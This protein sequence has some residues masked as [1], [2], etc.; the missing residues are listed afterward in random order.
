MKK[1]ALGILITMVSLPALS[2]VNYSAELLSG[3]TKHETKLND[4]N[5]WGKKYNSSNIVSGFGLRGVY[6]I[7]DIFSAELAYF[8]YG[9]ND[10]DFKFKSVKVTQKISTTSF[11]LGIKSGVRFYEDYLVYLRLGT[12]FWLV[13][14]DVD[15]TTPFGTKNQTDRDRNFYQGGGLQYKINPQ[16]SVGAE[17]TYTEMYISLKGFKKEEHEIRNLSLSL[18]YHF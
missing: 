8:D 10:E 11:N 12:S 17:F 14:A 1:L 5:S 7:G 3:I 4:K 15:L 13:K 9:D 2:E 16:F 18:A 6:S